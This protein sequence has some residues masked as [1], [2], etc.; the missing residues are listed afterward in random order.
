MESTATRNPQKTRA[1]LLEAAFKEIY[2]NGYQA[3]SL[4]RILANTNLTKG[5]LYHHFPNKRALGLAVIREVI[6]DQVIAAN[7]GN[8][9]DTDD[10]IPAMLAHIDQ[11][12]DDSAAEGLEYGCPLHNLVQEMSPLDEEFRI[13][14]QK[15][16][17]TWQRILS[18]SLAR[19]QA[20]GNVRA[21]VDCDEVALFLVAAVEGCKGTT[22]SLQSLETFRSCMNQ[23]KRY[24]ETLR[25]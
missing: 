12:C 2:E 23:L 7:A 15:I 19:G 1:A 11:C 5:A 24:I 14:L 6:N 4:E 10:P 3:A 16:Q 22:K 13:S 20:K 17:F 21:E 25:P 18:E 9:M 8:L